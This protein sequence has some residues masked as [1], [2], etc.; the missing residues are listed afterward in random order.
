MLSFIYN[1]PFEFLNYIFL[2]GN[3]D[4]STTI[5]TS[6]KQ[7]A[8]IKLDLAKTINFYENS[9]KH[10]WKTF[11]DV[12]QSD[13]LYL[14]FAPTKR[15]PIFDWTNMVAA[16]YYYSF[17]LG[18]IGLVPVKIYVVYCLKFYYLL[19]IF[20]NLVMWGL[21]LIFFFFF[22]IIN[23]FIY[24]FNFIYNF[25]IIPYIIDGV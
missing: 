19:F 6:E 25:L 2:G 21:K 18:L 23:S 17:L 3:V 9:E 16:R 5:T 15:R 7:L 11:K 14:F 4:I 22:I 8:L 12:Y 10:Y 24:L 1:F 13:Y 20:I